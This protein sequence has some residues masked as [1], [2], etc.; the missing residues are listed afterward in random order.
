MLHAVVSMPTGRPH[1][2]DLTEPPNV[3]EARDGDGDV[4]PEDPTLRAYLAREPGAADALVAEYRGVVRDAIVR[5]LGFRARSRM[6]LADDLTH[7][8]FLAL[9]RDDGRK[10]RTFAG[11]HGCSFA[12]W[13]KVVAVRLAIDRLRR[14]SRMV[15]LDDETPHM[16]ELKRSLR[17]DGGDPEAAMQGSEVAERLA[18]AF[19]ELGPKDRMLAELHLL[20]GRA[21]ED[22]AETLGVTMNAAYVRKSRLLERLR[23]SLSEGQ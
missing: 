8:V 11:R 23:R 13:L 15:A 10:L 20:R 22:I 3:T 5:F 18:R 9:L 14:E 4:R 12:G 16:L 17:S 1:T 6:D 2:A 21:L 19:A 7:E